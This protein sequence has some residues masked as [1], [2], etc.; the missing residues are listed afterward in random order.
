MDI[1]LR[2]IAVGGMMVG[3]LILCGAAAVDIV[4]GRFRLTAG[5][6]QA[7]GTI[8]A[9]FAVIWV[10][11]K[12]MK[13]ED[14]RREN[15]IH[16]IAV[17]TAMKIH[18]DAIQYEMKLEEIEL[19]MRQQLTTPVCSMEE[20]KVFILDSV[21]MPMS[22]VNA[23]DQAHTFRRFRKD[24]QHMCF[25]ARLVLNK[26]SARGT[27]EQEF[28]QDLGAVSSLHEACRCVVDGIE[29]LLETKMRSATRPWNK[30]PPP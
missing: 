5:W 22:L 28:A 4:D 7:I 12:Q 6:V 10:H 20:M 18:V 2:R 9:F 15:D 25:M 27:N 8:A 17:S 13:R 11:S 23:L 24:Y 3:F 21:E 14:E 30:R 19:A 26:V 16:S 1:W 29:K